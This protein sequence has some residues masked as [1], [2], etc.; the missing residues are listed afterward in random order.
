MKLG[1]VAIGFDEA[2]DQGSHKKKVR[3]SVIWNTSILA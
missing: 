3:F 1:S 2:M